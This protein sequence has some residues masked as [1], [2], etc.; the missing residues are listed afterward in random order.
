MEGAGGCEMHFGGRWGGSLMGSKVAGEKESRR[1]L[2]V[3]A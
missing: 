1:A 3:V 2:R